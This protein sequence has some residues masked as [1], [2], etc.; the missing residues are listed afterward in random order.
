MAHNLGPHRPV[1]VNTTN[2]RHHKRVKSCATLPNKFIVQQKLTFAQRAF[3][4]RR[5][6]TQRNS[7]RTHGTPT[8]SS[9]LELL[10]LVRNPAA[11]R[12]SDANTDADFQQIKNHQAQEQP[13]PKRRIQHSL[14]F[15]HL[16]WARWPRKS[17]FTYRT[18]SQK[19]R[20]L[21]GSTEPL[22]TNIRT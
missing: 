12:S 8:L 9:P 5:K 20:L 7:A 15:P 19:L 10:I 16:L 21:S 2:W 18:N 6:Y 17:A 22:F 11:N 3:L 1:T 13:T 4:Q 14:A